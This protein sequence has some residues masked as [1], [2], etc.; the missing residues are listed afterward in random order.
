MAEFLHAPTFKDTVPY[1]NYQCSIFSSQIGII[2]SLGT[3][4]I[5]FIHHWLLYICKMKYLLFADIHLHA[6]CKGTI[7]EGLQADTWLRFFPEKADIAR[8]HVF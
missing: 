4:S 6:S 3:N 7:W 2:N 5:L 8:Y 1:V